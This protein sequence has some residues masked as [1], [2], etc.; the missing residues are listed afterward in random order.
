MIKRRAA[1]ITGC[2]EVKVIDQEPELKDNEVLIKV[3]ASLISPGT[4]MAGVKA[5]RENPDKDAETKVFGYANAGEIIEEAEP[6][7]F[8]AAPKSDRTR[9]FLEQVLTH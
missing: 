8:F 6:E 3:H 9:T 5:K 1:A 7:T 4:E 2:G